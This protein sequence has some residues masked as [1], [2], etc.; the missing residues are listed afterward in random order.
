MCVLWLIVTVIQVVVALTAW[1]IW[2]RIRKVLESECEQ[3][4]DAC[5]CPA[6]KSVPF[7][8]KKKNWKLSCLLVSPEVVSWN[9]TLFFNLNNPPGLTRTWLG[10]CSSIV[11][12]VT[13]LY[14]F[15]NPSR[16]SVCDY[17]KAH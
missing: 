16:L 8:G 6:D 12:N 1:L 13:L 3:I 10:M 15:L 14:S 4:G 17:G 9:L 5:V 2:Y 11:E 7:T